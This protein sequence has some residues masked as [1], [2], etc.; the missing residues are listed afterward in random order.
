[1]IKNQKDSLEKENSILKNDLQALK[2]E[3]S[4]SNFN[5]NK[6]KPIMNGFS[7][8]KLVSDSVDGQ[9]VNP[10]MHQGSQKMVDPSQVG[11]GG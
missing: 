11:I 6:D 4:L 8:L 3:A 7:S 9:G 5:K 10:I 2:R 1:M